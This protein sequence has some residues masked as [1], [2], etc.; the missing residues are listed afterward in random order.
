MR[1]LVTGAN[2][3]LGRYIAEQLLARGD[4]V[5]AL[6]R[7]D[8]AALRHGGAE[9]FLG[10]ITNAARVNAACQNIDAVFH[11]AARAGL[12]GPWRLYYEPNVR[13][14]QNVIAACRGAGV[15]KLIFTSSP[16]VTFAGV[17]QEHVDEAAPYADRW[18]AHYPHSKALAEQQVL[19][20][21][22]ESASVSSANAG[23]ALLTCSL[24]P[25]LIWGPRDQHLVP[26][27]IARAKLGRLR[28]IGDGQ[29]LVD[30]IYVENAARAHLQAC[31]A[32]EPGSPVCGQ[33]YFLSQGEPVNCWGWINQILALADLPPVNRS[34]SYATASRIG[35]V[36][37]TAWKLL[38]KSSDPP[39]TRFL[40][41]QLATH[42]YFDISKA[43][44]DFNYEPLVSLQEGM[45]RLAAACQWPLK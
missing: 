33:A 45:Q 26:K 30:V 21:N 42:H 7:R 2:G 18:L 37:E 22:R 40:A 29:N 6:V 25:H 14:T 12:A 9:I 34:L 32:L 11:V 35:A 4:R 31:D 39:M 36:C 10:D 16:S 28:R 20:A 5:R 3:F 38:G 23:G 41:A 15:Q 1:A 17:D 8:D 24:R 19:A 13:G 43:R 44:C 27:L